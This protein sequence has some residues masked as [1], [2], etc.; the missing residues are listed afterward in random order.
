MT[1]PAISSKTVDLAAESLKVAPQSIEA[2]QAVLGGL[3]LDNEAWDKISD[4]VIEDDF[5]RRD[6]RLIFRAIAALADKG[7]PCDVVTLSEWLESNNHLEAA[8]GL[9]HLGAL[10][11]NTPSAANILAYAKIVRE[12]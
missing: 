5:Y 3:M 7:S 12:R 10:A 6:H 4:I 9:A 1:E 8:G 2:E 11:K